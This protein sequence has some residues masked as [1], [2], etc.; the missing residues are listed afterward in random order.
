MPGLRAC[1]VVLSLALAASGCSLFGKK[2]AGPETLPE[3][4]TQAQASSGNASAPVGQSKSVGRDEEGKT[5]RPPS[6][7]PTVMRVAS[8]ELPMFRSPE[9]AAKAG[10][11]RAPEV[12]VARLRKGDVV[13]RFRSEKGF[14]YV[15]SVRLQRAGWVREICLIPEP[16]PERA[17]GVPGPSPEIR[18]PVAAEPQ[19]PPPPKDAPRVTEPGA[20]VSDS[21]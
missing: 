15:E 7:E 17:P 19:A 3:E 12:A 18:Q 1:V 13:R 9:V 10:V 16:S 5:A 14:A 11:G 2:S 6:G 8:E 20:A 21:F 4:P